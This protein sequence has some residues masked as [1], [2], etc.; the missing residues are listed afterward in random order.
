MLTVSPGSVHGFSFPRVNNS[1]PSAEQTINAER[2]WEERKRELVLE[3]PE[4][5]HKLVHIELKTPTPSIMP[6]LQSK[7]TPKQICEG[8]AQRL[9]RPILRSPSLQPGKHDNVVRKTWSA[10]CFHRLQA[11]IGPAAS[12]IGRP[13]F[14]LQEHK[15][16]KLIRSRPNRPMTAK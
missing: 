2:S 11:L 15:N 16:Q 5:V 8:H 10:R 6:R 14:R 1:F 4:R 7:S 12:N 3:V 13:G 9:R